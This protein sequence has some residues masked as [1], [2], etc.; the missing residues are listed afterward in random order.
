M[1]AYRLQARGASVLVLEAAGRV[2]GRVYTERDFSDGLTAEAGAHDVHEA[3]TETWDLVHELDLPLV[4]WPE[5]EAITVCR[6]GGR[7][8]VVPS[9]SLPHSAPDGLS[10]EERSAFPEI[11]DFLLERDVAA[12]RGA[13]TPLSASV[14]SLDGESVAARLQ[15]IGASPAAREVVRRFLPVLPE[16]AS[17]LWAAWEI[18]ADDPGV[19]RRPFRIDGGND[20]LPEEIRRRLGGAVLTGRRVTDVRTDPAAVVVVAQGPDGPERHASRAIV[21]AIPL[22]AYAAVEWQRL[23]ETKR[24][25]AQRVRQVAEAVTHFEVRASEHLATSGTATSFGD[26]PIA[27]TN[28]T[29]AAAPGRRSILE[30]WSERHGADILDGAG[31]DV[32][33]VARRDLLRLFPELDGAIERTHHLSWRRFPGIGGAG[34]YF[35]PGQVGR[36]LAELAAPE[37]PLFFAGDHASERPT[38]TVGAIRSGERA[39]EQAWAWLRR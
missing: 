25:A 1:A 38:W 8:S 30:A 13:G 11:L 22:A 31:R 29:A 21:V 6:W 34:A 5:E 4:R 20:R 33:D 37:P 17:V 3:H 26:G 12:L 19:L 32:E 16:E 23:G 18:A 10:S 15:S 36:Y 14:R 28:A 2:G 9:A 7:R 35:G 39:A 27:W 24:E